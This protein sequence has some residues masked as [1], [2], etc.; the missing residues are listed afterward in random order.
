MGVGSF[1]KSLRLII[2]NR[3]QGG[4]T[5]KQ[6]LGYE[7]MDD[8]P[9]SS[10][11]DPKRV[12]LCWRAEVVGTWC[13]SQLPALKGVKGA[14]WKLQDL[15]RKRDKLFSY[16]V[17]HSKPTNKLVSSHSEHSW[18]WDKPRATRTHLTH[19]GPDSGEAITFPHIVFSVLLCR[20]YIWMVFFL[21]TPKVESRNCPGLDSWDFGHS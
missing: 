10:L 12:Q 8:V 3:G 21:G 2:N 7:T 16:A 18:C 19:H 13:R 15:T 14:C 4:T 20:T 5:S 17:L 11:L 6:A 9:P 1:A